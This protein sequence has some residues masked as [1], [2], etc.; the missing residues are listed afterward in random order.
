[1]SIIEVRGLRKSFGALSVPDGVDLAGA[2]DECIGII[3]D[4]SVF[5]RCL[6]EREA[7]AN[8]HH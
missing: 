4:K 6:T 5:L 1:M 3:G 8:E 7:A 2:A